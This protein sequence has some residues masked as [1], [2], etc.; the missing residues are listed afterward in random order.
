MQEMKFTKK[1][2]TL[3]KS[4]I[5]D[6][7]EAYMDK[8]NK[9][10]IEL[11]SGDADPSD[12]FWRLEKRIREDR[13][14]TGVRVEMSRSNM[15]YNIVALINDGAIGLEDLEEFSGGLKE[16]VRFWVER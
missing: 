8:L 14:K 15:V 5:V 16:N 3:F 2:W 7:Q 10:Y 12:K 6:W 13:E 1:D 11:L 4:K 9:E